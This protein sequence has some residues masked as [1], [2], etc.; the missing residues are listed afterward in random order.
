MIVK[1][2]KSH[3]LPSAIWK[4]RKASGIVPV[5]TRRAENQGSQ[6]DKS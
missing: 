2:E 1:D 4:I 3:D 5:Q 6:W